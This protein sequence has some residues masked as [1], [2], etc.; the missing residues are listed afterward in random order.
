[1]TQLQG[2]IWDFD[3]LI[4]D[5]E[6]SAF[7]TAEQIFAEHGLTL[8]MADWQHLVG[9]A[10]GHWTELLGEAL[11]EPISDDERQR[12]VLLRQQRHH[13]LLAELDAQPGVDTLLDEAAAAGVPSAVASSSTDEWVDRHL[14]RLGLRHHFSAIVTRDL[15][16]RER[17]KPHPDLFLV[18]AAALHADPRR[19]VVLED[20]PNGVLAAHAARMPVVA[21]PGGVTAAVDFPPADLSVASLEKVTLADLTRLVE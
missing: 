18:A 19:C 15:V 6:T 3:G 5:T 1:M 7:E 10:T 12:L 20:S 11:G 8:A 16:G 2:L 4:L 21:V 13:A 17:T 9:T 14:R